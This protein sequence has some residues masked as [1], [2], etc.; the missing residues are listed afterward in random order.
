MSEIPAPGPNGEVS[1]L[2]LS[3]ITVLDL[4]QIYNGPYAT[5]LM[6][7]AGATVIKI[8]PK[9]GENLRSRGDLGGVAYPYAMLNSNKKPVTLN[10]KSEKGKDILREMVAKADILIENFA[11]GVM[12][13]LGVGANELIENQ[14]AA[15]LRLQFRVWQRWSLSVLSRDG[16][17]H[18]GDVWRAE[19]HRLRRPASR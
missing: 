9:T 2:P 17:R 6:A 14:S 19:L 5:F 10:L 13:R 15:D 16:P 3:G 8:E 1:A 4:T 7:M 12:D 18:A 11:P